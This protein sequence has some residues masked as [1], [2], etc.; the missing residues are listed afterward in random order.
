MGT[1][2]T[3]EI[4]CNKCGS[5]DNQIKKGKTRSGSQRLFCK[6]CENKYTPLPKGY[7]E[8]TKKN[9]VK[10]YLSGTSARGVGKVMGMKGDTVTAWVNFFQSKSNQVQS[11]P[12]L[13]K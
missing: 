2:K 5:V 6:I 9:A 8:E 7:D 3:K 13:P 1:I 10:L 4:G 12:K 11:Q